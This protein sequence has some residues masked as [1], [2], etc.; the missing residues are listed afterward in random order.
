MDGLWKRLTHLKRYKNFSPRTIIDCG[1]YNG[2]WSKVAH[3]V[4]PNASMFMIEANASKRNTLEKTNIPFQIG[5]LGD[6]NNVYTN[7]YMTHDE[8]DRGNSV[9]RERTK[10]FL[11][12]NCSVTRLPMI[13]LDKIVSDN[14]LKN[15]DL[16]NFDL[17]GSEVDTIKGGEKIMKHVKYITISTQILEYNINAPKITDIILQLDKL[18]F[19]LYDIININYL[20]DRQKLKELELIFEKEQDILDSIWDEELTTINILEMVSDL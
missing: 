5:L 4:F 3:N 1:A 6:M 13:T 9:Y 2:E 17:N 16:I 14:N 20:N 18:G 11:D 7:Y 15:V 8:D 12:D 19:K 10:T